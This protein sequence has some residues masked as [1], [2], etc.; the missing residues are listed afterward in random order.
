MLYRAVPMPWHMRQIR[1]YHGGRDL[2][3]IS[4]CKSASVHFRPIL[5]LPQQ[6]G[7]VL[8]SFG[9][10]LLITAQLVV[11]VFTISIIVFPLS[12]HSTT[13]SSLCFTRAYQI[14]ILHAGGLVNNTAWHW[15][16]LHAGAYSTVPMYCCKWQR[17]HGICTAHHP[18]MFVLVVYDGTV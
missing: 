11:V 1:I 4:V 5:P 15:Q 3:C 8:A 17:R 7:S 12:L 2:Q 9:S 18:L 10:L 6:S 14:V 13:F 16:I